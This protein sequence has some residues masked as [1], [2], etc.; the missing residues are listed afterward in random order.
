MS[1]AWVIDACV[2]AKWWLSDEEHIA[3]AAQVLKAIREGII[4]PAVPDL[5]FYELA[6]VLVLAC[7]RKRLTREQAQ[8]FAL[9]GKAMP[10]LAFPVH[11]K[12]SRILELASQYSLSAYDAAYVALAESLGC[13][14]LTADDSLFE[15]VSGKCPF[16]HH[17]RETRR[18]FRIK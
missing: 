18:L 1:K 16:V 15:S 17:L 12:L 7:R 8:A 3:E 14:L 6:N 5:W 2:A 4:E 13:R 10:V 9:E 11:E